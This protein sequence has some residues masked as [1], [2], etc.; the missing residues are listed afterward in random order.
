MNTFYLTGI[1]V[2]AGVTKRKESL[3]SGCSEYREQLHVDKIGHT[4]IRTQP[5]VG[6]DACC[7][8]EEK[9]S[10]QPSYKRLSRENG[11]RA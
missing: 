7:S 10:D 2:D 9:A 4:L 3:P 8:R 1:M 6:R 11:I 5:Q